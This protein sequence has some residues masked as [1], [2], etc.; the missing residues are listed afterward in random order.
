M[1]TQDQ[2]LSFLRTTGPTIPSKVAKVIA[3]E[4]YL[5]SAHLSD[6]SSQ[7]KVK[8][9]HLKIGGSPL[10]YLPG[11]EE[12]LYSFAAGNMNPKDLIVLDRLKDS[13][14]LRE[15]DL[16]L[17]SKVALR[18]LKDF[19]IPLNVRTS[20]GSE[21]F[22]KWHLLPEGDTNSIISDVLNVNVKEKVDETPVIETKPEVVEEV[23]TVEETPA[24]DSAEESTEG[25]TEEAAVE[26]EVV[27]TEVESTPPAEE[28]PEPVKQ[29]AQRKKGTTEKSV[30]ET[31]TKEE[32]QGE[33][34]K[35]EKTEKET[36]TIHELEKQKQD[37]ELKEKEEDAAEIL[38]PSKRKPKQT[39]LSE[40]EKKPLIKKI[41]E[42]MGKKRG[43]PDTFFPQIEEHFATLD[44]RIE[45]HEIIRKNSEIN[46][47][48]KVP[49]VVG[50]MTYFCKA[51]SK[52]KCDE[53]DISAA[54]MEAQMKKLPLLF[55][56]TNQLTKKAQE[57]ID[58]NAFENAIIK[59]IE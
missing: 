14:V 9:S 34:E 50:S 57:M 46:M 31:P 40:E 8:I 58:G 10:Y 5:A 2:I 48:T 12:K 6:L 25:A 11:Q 54:Y 37:E 18:S 47:T 17:L 24:E 7:G 33:Y 28:E 52:S 55:L 51:K 36:P 45:E 22:W 30:D 3:T 53:K 27:E 1:T 41:K 32:A 59:K 23:P 19:A 13:K 16:D 20:A 35:T 43:T 15:M 29:S 4:I 21:L 49:S 26:E 42:K 38:K 56:Y 39:K 44:I